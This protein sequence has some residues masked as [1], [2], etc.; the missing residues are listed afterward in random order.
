MSYEDLMIRIRR[1]KEAE[2]KI[3]PHNREAVI[4]NLVFL[5]H[6][7]VA[8]ERL[9]SD[10]AYEAYQWVDPFYGRLSQYYNSHLA[11]EQGEIVVLKEDLAS[12]NIPL[13]IADRFVMALIGTQYYLIK[14]R[15]PVCLLG[16]LVVQE[17]DPTPVK[18]VE[19]LEDLYGRTLFRFLRM[20]AIKDLKHAKEILDLLETVPAA[21]RE[22]IF[23]SADNVLDYYAQEIKTYG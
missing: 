8:S 10:A 7:C 15:N 20:H 1:R 12:A 11:E 3:D 23:F 6:A 13:G 5:Y 16:Y 9:L 19:A 18:T 21:L 4:K 17:A 22:L 14:H 2:L